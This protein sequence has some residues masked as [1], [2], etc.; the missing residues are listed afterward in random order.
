MIY[1]NT[2]KA[3]YETVRASKLFFDNL[4][5]V[6][7][8]ELGFKKNPYDVCVV[9]RNIDS[10]QFTITWHVN[11]LKILPADPEVTT[12]I[13][14]L[15]RRFGDIMPLLISGG[16]VHEYLGMIFNY[17]KPGQVKITMYQYLVG[18]IKHDP[19][20]YKCGSTH[21]TPA[22]SHFFILEIL[23]KIILVVSPYI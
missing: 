23:S 18:I 11:D 21:A 7:I 5:A 10:K 6:L 20:V 16:K 12:I 14:K 13:N 22:S 15:D 2:L 1:S 17:I 19:D 8:D 9:N 4:S 3:L